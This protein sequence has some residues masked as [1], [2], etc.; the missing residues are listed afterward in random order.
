LISQELVEEQVAALAGGGKE[1]TRKTVEA[2]KYRLEVSDLTRSVQDLE[3][4]GQVISWAY[5]QPEEDEQILVAPWGVLEFDAR[6]TGKLTDV[7]TSV[8]S[9]TVDGK[10]TR[11]VERSLPLPGSSSGTQGDT[12]GG[13]S[14]HTDRW[15]LRPSWNTSDTL[16]VEADAAGAVER[17]LTIGGTFGET[18]WHGTEGRHVYDEWLYDS[19]VQG[20]AR[21][22]RTGEY[23]SSGFVWTDTARS[24]TVTSQYDPDGKLL[25]ASGSLRQQIESGGLASSEDQEYATRTSGDWEA[26][27][28]YE[29]SSSDNFRSSLTR[30]WTPR[31]TAAGEL[32]YEATDAA[33]T[34]QFWGEYEESDT[35]SVWD[36]HQWRLQETERTRGG[37]YGAGVSNPLVQTKAGGAALDLGFY[38]GG[39]H[40]WGYEGK[41]VHAHFSPATLG[42]GPGEDLAFWDDSANPDMAAGPSLLRQ[43]GGGGLETGLG[44]GSD[45]DQI[46][47]AWARVPA[48][49]EANP[50][51][52]YSRV[53]YEDRITALSGIAALTWSDASDFFW[54]AS[55]WENVSGAAKA[56]ITA[57]FKIV[58]QSVL[59]VADGLLYVVNGG[60]LPRA[61][62][63]LGDALRTG[64]ITGAQAAWEMG[65]FILAA[66]LKQQ[67]DAASHYWNGDLSEQEYRDQV[68]GNLWGVY[69]SGRSIVTARRAATS[70]ASRPIPVFATV[71]TAEGVVAVVQVGSRTLSPA[72]AGA[73]AGA[74][75]GGLIVLMAAGNIPDGDLPTSNA[76]SKPTVPDAVP[77]NPYFTRIDPKVPNRPDPKFSIDS[78]TFTAGEVTSKGGLRNTKEFWQQWQQLRPES[79]SKSNR[80]LIENY[81]KLKV[82]PRID[83]EWIKVFPEHAP[84]KGDL[85]IHHHVDFGRYTIPVPGQTHVGSGGVWHTK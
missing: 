65:T 22:M 52:Y 31:V 77:D 46:L 71:V 37:A 73:V 42:P 64:Q 8:G 17:K 21:E 39:H 41:A 62:S 45:A 44:P 75:T 67:Y 9:G 28:S 29:R 82:S 78:S 26:I 81:D 53:E 40:S 23:D 19:Y 60:Y 10:L 49:V 1:T 54:N 79:L 27:R 38:N 68:A 57:P 7:M 80:Y 14:E 63:E 25:S 2:G 74:G 20:M 11:R 3:D 84:F 33:F 6:L 34:Q 69:L 51:K 48:D 50:G 61:Y 72:L 18:L 66:G 16:V 70:L 30:D 4:F 56:T 83:D 13:F 47:T 24:G 15:Q 58:E 36:G 43:D 12:H 59:M 85:I 55:S 32:D 5:T 76:P 35:R